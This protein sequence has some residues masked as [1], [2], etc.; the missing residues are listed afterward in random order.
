MLLQLCYEIIVRRVRY[1]FARLSVSWCRA[2]FHF[3]RRFPVHL[4]EYSKFRFD[5]FSCTLSR[6]RRIRV[7]VCLY[8][9]VCMCTGMCNLCA[10]Y[11]EINSRP[12]LLTAEVCFDVAEIFIHLR[13]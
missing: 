4:G 7:H 13:N 3:I 12:T 8:M 6:S 2:M 5:I 1:Y 10:R 11:F 9:C